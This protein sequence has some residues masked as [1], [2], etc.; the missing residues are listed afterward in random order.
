MSKL[1]QSADL[2]D[3]SQM[4]TSRSNLGGFQMKFDLTPVRAENNK[5]TI[6]TGDN[7]VNGKQNRTFADSVLL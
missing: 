6:N 5:L 1:D 3:Q 7:T 2:N 4:I